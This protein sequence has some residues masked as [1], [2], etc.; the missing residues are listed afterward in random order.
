M[1]TVGRRGLLVLMAML[2]A[3]SACGGPS[4]TDMEGAW[5]KAEQNAQKY[6]SK[7][8]SFKGAIDELVASSKTSFDEAKKAD[9][10][11]RGEKM[12]VAVDKVT[13]SL[14]PFEAYE[15]ALEGL[16]VLMKDKELN[17][18]PASKFN[19]ANEAAKEAIKK[20]EETLK[21]SPANMGEAKG[22]IEAAVKG[23]E[24]A[25]KGL[26][27][28]KAKP[29]SGGTTSSPTSAPTSAPKK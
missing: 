23:L 1:K 11:V 14:A 6:A 4:E 15:K 3:T 5:N 22:K 26:D 19:P 20:G 12:K 24:E 7:Y 25:A 29:A 8:P 9:E 28:L 2:L 17:D 13:G 18:L 27:S 16:Q 10:K 21:S